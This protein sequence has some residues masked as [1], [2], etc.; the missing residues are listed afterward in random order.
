MGTS[1]LEGAKLGIPTILLDYSFHQIEKLYM[2]KPVFEHDGFSLGA[3]IHNSS[4]EDTCSLGDLL[5]KILSNYE[6]YSYKSY[7]YWKDNFSPEVFRTDFDRVLSQCTFSIS[8]IGGRCGIKSIYCSV[9]HPTLLLVFYHLGRRL[10]HLLI[11]PVRIKIKP[12]KR[13]I[14]ALPFQLSSELLCIST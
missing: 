12:L 1:A 10:R 3:K 7:N 9:T 8:N 4:F 13:G 2:F 5:S 14:Y 6:E 11:Q